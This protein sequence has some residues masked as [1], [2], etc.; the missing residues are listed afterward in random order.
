MKYNDI[1]HIDKDF[2]SPGTKVNNQ[3]KIEEFIRCM[4]SLKKTTNHCHVKIQFT[5]MIKVIFV[6]Q[7][8]LSNII[9]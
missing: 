1:V 4:K 2:K 3:F 9:I 8:E 5:A 7:I 6:F